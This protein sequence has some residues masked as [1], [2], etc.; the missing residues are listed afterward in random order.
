MAEVASLAHESTSVNVK[1]GK[2][3]AS[4][5]FLTQACAM[6]KHT[7]NWFYVPHPYHAKKWTGS[8]GLKG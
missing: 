2:D 1:L 6:E 4:E 5:D 7:S 3:K 8:C